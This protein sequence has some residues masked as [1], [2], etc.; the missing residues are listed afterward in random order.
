M[1]SCGG[2]KSLLLD[3]RT[4]AALSGCLLLSWC[5]PLWDGRYFPFAQAWHNELFCSLREVRFWK[6][7]K[8]SPL[9]GSRKLKQPGCWQRE[10]VTRWVLTLFPTSPVT[11]LLS[12][13]WWSC[14]LNNT[15]RRAPL[16]QRFQA[17]CG[18]RLHGQCRKLRSLRRR[19]SSSRDLFILSSKNCSSICSCKEVVESR[20]C[21]IL[22]SDV[23]GKKLCSHSTRL[24]WA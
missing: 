24:I 20:F 22:Q 16:W 1:G 2:D 14:V 13:L 8:L 15:I 21:H 17:S 19:Y 18:K 5:F 11:L 6:G 12:R 10:G 23:W 4:V 7:Y 9:I 3:M